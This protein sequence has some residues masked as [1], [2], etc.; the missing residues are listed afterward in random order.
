MR[1]LLQRLGL[2]RGSTCSEAKQASQA[3]HQNM[4]LVAAA[5]EIGRR[6]IHEFL[7]GAEGYFSWARRCGAQR[8]DLLKNDGVE[9]GPYRPCMSC[10]LPVHGNLPRF[11]CCA[12]A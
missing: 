7:V 5:F 6:A 11:N 10:G 12:S 1:G 4:S 9:V 2:I 3:L 8:F